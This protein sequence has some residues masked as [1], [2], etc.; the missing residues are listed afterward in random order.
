MQGR[1]SNPHSV[2]PMHGAFPT[3]TRCHQMDPRTEMCGITPKPGGLGCDPEC[4]VCTETPEGFKVNTEGL[5]KHCSGVWRCG[6]A[7]LA[8]LHPVFFPANKWAGRWRSP[9]APSSP[10]DHLTACASLCRAT[11]ATWR[12]GSAAAARTPAG[13]ECRC[14]PTAPGAPRTR[15]SPTRR[16]GAS[17]AGTR[18]GLGGQSIL[19]TMGGD[20]LGA[21]EPGLGRS[22]VP[23]CSTAADLPLPAAF[24][25]LALCQH[26]SSFPCLP[27][28]EGCGGLR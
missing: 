24:S 21:T 3:A 11:A 9:P 15:R 17:A 19:R 4:L 26:Q 1:S 22:G 16:V 12:W 28:A 25:P 18:R 5:S 20:Q 23:C 7:V 13:R 10:A 6:A 14:H 27:P 2:C 8:L